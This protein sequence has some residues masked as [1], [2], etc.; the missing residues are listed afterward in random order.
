MRRVDLE[1]VNRRMS[2]TTREDVSSDA[3]DPALVRVG[4]T[5]A[6]SV[7]A[8]PLDSLRLL[9]GIVLGCQFSGQ[10]FH[11]EVVD[12]LVDSSVRARKPV[13]DTSEVA[14]DSGRYPRLL[15]D[16]ARGRL[17]GGL[18]SLQMPLRQAPLQAAGA[19][20]PRYD[21]DVGPP[22][23]RG[24]D[25]AAGARLVD[26]RERVSPDSVGGGASPPQLLP[27]P[28]RQWSRSRH[29]SQSGCGVPVRM[30]GSARHG[31]LRG[32]NA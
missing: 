1:A 5:R 31:T 12:D 8:Y 24:Y 13:V 19:I 9:V 29:I 22:L 23:L 10:L 14:Q 26:D 32:C 30:P 4:Q 3:D 15:V 17:L 2:I 28:G 7:H 20:A 16:F 21:D 27:H 18:G 25:H 6:D 11:E